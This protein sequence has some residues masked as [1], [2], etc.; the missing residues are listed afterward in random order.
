MKS[1]AEILKRILQLEAGGGIP[2]KVQA[3]AIQKHI[4]SDGA[5][6]PESPLLREFVER[7][8]ATLDAMDRATSAPPDPVSWDF[9]EEHDDDE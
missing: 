4:D 2:P 1:R 5:W 7:W 8:S 9:T 6:V 3:W